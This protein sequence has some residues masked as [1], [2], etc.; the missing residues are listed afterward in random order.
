MM[1]M[2]C[3]KKGCLDWKFNPLGCEKGE[4]RLYYICEDEV[5]GEVLEL[6]IVSSA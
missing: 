1:M 4:H 2:M 5:A 6:Y 3:T